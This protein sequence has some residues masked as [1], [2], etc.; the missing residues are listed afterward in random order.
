MYGN[1]RIFGQTLTCPEILMASVAGIVSCEELI[2]NEAI[3]NYP[4]LTEIPFLAVHAVCPQKFG[5]YP[6]AVWGY[7]WFDMDFLREWR[8]TGLELRIKKNI[9][10]LKKYYD[11]YFYECD[12][13][14]DFLEKIGYKRLA[15]A[16]DLDRGQRVILD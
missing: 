2:S 5:G 4:N 16:R 1:C 14:E 6:G 8:A 15:K 11:K 9:D 7:H 3:R 13:W 12:T 10:P